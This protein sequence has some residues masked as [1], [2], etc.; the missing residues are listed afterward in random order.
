MSQSVSQFKYYRNKRKKVL[1][2]HQA[3]ESCSIWRK[4]LKAGMQ[5]A[6]TEQDMKGIALNPAEPPELFHR[7]RISCH[8]PSTASTLVAAHIIP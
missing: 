3:A 2:F 5:A 4:D 7:S 1:G 8:P 6:V